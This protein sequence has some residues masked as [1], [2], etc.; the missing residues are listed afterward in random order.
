MIYKVE[1]W[2]LTKVL[3]DVSIAKAIESLQK[4]GL[5]I[6]LVVD[7]KNNLIGTITDGD[8]R[9]YLLTGNSIYENI[10]KVVNIQCI[11]ADIGTSDQIIESLIRKNFIN[12]IPILSKN[13]L[14]G[15]YKLS[16]QMQIVKN[17]KKINE[18]VLIMAGGKGQRL[19]PLTLKTPKAMLKVNDKP[20]LEILLLN[21][22][23]Y[24]FNN[25]IFSVNYLSNKIISYFKDGK[26]WGVKIS[27]IKEKKPLGTAGCLAYLKKKC[28]KNILVMNCD[29]HTNINF[30]DLLNYHK[31][32]RADL[33][34]VAKIDQRISKFGIIK[35]RG[36]NF[37]NFEEK[38]TYTDYINAGVYVFNSI[39]FKYLNKKYLDIPEFLN[40]LK[41]KKKKIIIYPI[42]EY[43]FDIG[44]LNTYN[45]FKLYSSKNK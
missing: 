36:I 4:S 3:E 20:L 12:S 21:A 5:Q 41:N 37:A 15:L 44:S 30:S 42:Y 6:V 10:K 16:N 23:S 19:R 35:T 40:I 38:Y 1:N 43:W 45:K 13:K 31:K 8:I 32:N 34:M 7:K 27:Y 17:P 39:L 33:T 25:F 24:G 11:K 22:I 26:K 29:V 2:K 9:R 18:K 28:S 14:I